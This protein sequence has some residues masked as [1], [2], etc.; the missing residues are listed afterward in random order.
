MSTPL[1]TPCTVVLHSLTHAVVLYLS[2]IPRYILSC[3]ILHATQTASDTLYRNRFDLPNHLCHAVTSQAHDT[4][5][6]TSLSQIANK[7]STLSST[8]LAMVRRRPE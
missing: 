4:R 8:L 1:H 7:I 2:A 6:L 5:P 3:S